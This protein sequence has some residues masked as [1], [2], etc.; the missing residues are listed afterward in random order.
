MKLKFRIL[1]MCLILSFIISACGS[2]ASDLGTESVGVEDDTTAVM[3]TEVT[4]VTEVV[5]NTEDTQKSEDAEVNAEPELTAEEKEALEKEEWRYYM[6]PDVKS[7]LKVRSEADAESEVAGVLKKWDRAKVLEKGVTWTKIESGNLVGYVPNEYC[8]YGYEALE[9]AKENCDT[10]A[11]VTIDGLRIRQEM[12]TESKIMK[13]LEEGDTVV[14]DT[15][16]EV[17]EDWVAVKYKDDTCYVSAKYVTVAMNIGT[18]LT[19]EEIEE[20]RRKE[21][22]AKAAAEAAK[23]KKQQQQNSNSAVAASVDDMTLMA[24]IIYCEAGGEPY[25]TQLAVGA[26]IMN[27]IRSVGY[28]NNLYDV[29]YQRGQFGPARTGKLARVISQGKATS[30]CYSAA[31]AAFGGADNTGGCL[32]FNDHNGTRNGL[33]IGGMVFW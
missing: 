11:K 15:A 5:E 8:M 6:L 2:A 12:D 30:S 25:E 19:M 9:Y 27:R 21:E 10:V 28:P 24:A 14:V 13:R 31:Q 18:G 32:H 16:A 17:E 20:I 1:S 33:V 23:K 26:V 4:E 29:I 3:S 22:E 7:S